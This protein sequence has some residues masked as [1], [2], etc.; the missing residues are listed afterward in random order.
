M[1]VVDSRDGKSRIQRIVTLADGEII[2]NAF[3]DRD[4]QENSP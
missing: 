1:W 3:F 2:H 4:F